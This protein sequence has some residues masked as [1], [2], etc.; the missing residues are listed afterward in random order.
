MIGTSYYSYDFFVHHWHPVI[1]TFVSSVLVRR[2]VVNQPNL[3]NETRRN[4]SSSTFCLQIQESYLKVLS[5]TAVRQ[6]FW[7]TDFLVTQNLARS[8]TTSF[9]YTPGQY[10]F[11]YRSATNSVSDPQWSALNSIKGQKLG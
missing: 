3:V 8:Y 1:V 11:F 9:C 6:H 5:K 4:N 7:I 10:F 2:Y